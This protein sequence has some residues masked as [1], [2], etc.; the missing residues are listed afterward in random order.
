MIKDKNLISCLITNYIIIIICISF[1]VEKLERFPQHTLFIC[2]TFYSSRWSQIKFAKNI[3]L[4]IEVI[5]FV[6]I[7]IQY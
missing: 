4:K 3:S 7:G 1:Y 2:I 6:N 5:P